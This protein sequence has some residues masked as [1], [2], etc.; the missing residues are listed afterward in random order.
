MTER[1][2]HI[3][4]VR[5]N[6]SQ[7]L[8]INDRFQVLT[9]RSLVASVGQ[10]LADSCR[11]GTPYQRGFLCVGRPGY[12]P[13]PSFERIFGTAGIERKVDIR[14]IRAMVAATQRSVPMSESIPGLCLI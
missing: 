9:C 5:F 13:H 7:K 10:K 12:D 4:G 3:E 1:R 2:E 6:L 11:S 14:T 8:Y